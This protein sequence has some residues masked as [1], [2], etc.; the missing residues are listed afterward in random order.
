LEPKT[1]M[2]VYVCRVHK[3]TTI[4]VHPHAHHEPKNQMLQ[5]ENHQGPHAQYS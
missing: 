4:P 3:N 2:C 5:T 1:N